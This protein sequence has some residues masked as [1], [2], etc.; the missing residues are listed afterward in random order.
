[1]KQ[2]TQQS[3]LFEDAA[4]VS[5]VEHLA[6]PGGG[7]SIPTLPLQPK[8]LRLDL[9]NRATAHR[10]WTTLHYLHR[11]F[12]GASL[13]LGVYSPDMSEVVG[14]IAFSQ[15]FGGSK[16]GGA[17]HIW[18]IRRMW[19]SDER[20]ARNSESRVLSIACR[21][22]VKRIAPHVNQIISYSDL[23]KMGHKGTI[24]RAAGFVFHGMTAVDPNGQGWATHASH[25]AAD[26]W[27]KKRWI[28]WLK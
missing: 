8:Q 12:T 25:K 24:Y 1:M 10:I 21:V 22:W 4:E 19:L 18:E 7:G 6:P 14:A 27:P 15:R 26:N 20:C 11:D 13:E 9:L 5:M 2:S 28:L 17:P 3:K 16:I 23:L